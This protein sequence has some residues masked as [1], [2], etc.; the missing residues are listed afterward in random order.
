[1]PEK[2]HWLY[3]CIFIIYSNGIFFSYKI[4][5]LAKPIGLA[6]LVVSTLG[7]YAVYI[8]INHLII[9]KIISKK[10]LITIEILL[11]ITLYALFESDIMFENR[12][13]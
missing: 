1:M 5:M 11:L 12:L 9:K 4:R 3:I 10:V 2:S 7:F 8:V 6:L 13:V